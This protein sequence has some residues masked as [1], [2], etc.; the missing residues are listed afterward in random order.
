MFVSYSEGGGGGGDVG[1]DEMV[2]TRPVLPGLKKKFSLAQQQI[3]G[4]ISSPNSRLLNNIKK[5][6]NVNVT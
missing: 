1:V 5:Y 4:R 3:T 6:Y 2:V